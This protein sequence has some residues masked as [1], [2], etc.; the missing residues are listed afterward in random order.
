[1]SGTIICLPCGLSPA[2]VIQ[3]LGEIATLGLDALGQPELAAIVP[4]VEKLALDAE[5][6]VTGPTAGEVL[7][8]EVDASQAAGDALEDAKFPR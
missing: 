5:G 1:M 6:L 4:I 3:G 8:T 2:A 7:A